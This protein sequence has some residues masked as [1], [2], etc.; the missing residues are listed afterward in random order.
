MIRAIAACN[1]SADKSKS[2]PTLMSDCYEYSAP[3]NQR[4]RALTAVKTGL[5]FWYLVQSAE[6]CA[7]SHSQKVSR[8]RSASPDK[9]PSKNTDGDQTQ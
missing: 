3:N 9:D 7:Y 5:R 8:A 6:T 2:R 1:P 4:L